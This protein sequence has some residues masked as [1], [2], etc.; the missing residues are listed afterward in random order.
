MDTRCKRSI[1]QRN[2]A[3]TSLHERDMLHNCTLV[4]DIESW[5]TISKT[6]KKKDA[7][8]DLLL[9]S[10]VRTRWC[11]YLTRLAQ[12]VNPF[13]G[14][15]P[16]LVTHLCPWSGHYWSRRRGQRLLDRWRHITFRKELGMS[17]SCACRSTGKVEKGC[18]S[19]AVRLEK[20][21]RKGKRSEGYLLFLKPDSIYS[22]HRTKRAIQ[23][24]PL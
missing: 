21:K 19:A 22:L 17:V 2:H 18:I 1:G 10:E 4:V 23:L 14:L 24:M 3:C 15:W 7:W 5:G 8:N 9:I 12:I 13:L 20:E 11:T 6:V 16:E